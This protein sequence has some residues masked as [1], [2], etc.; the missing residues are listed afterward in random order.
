MPPNPPSSPASASQLPAAPASATPANLAKAALRRLAEQRLE[1]TPDNFRKAYEVEAGVSP[2]APAVPDRVAASEPVPSQAEEGERWSKLIGRILR[3]AERGGRQWTAARKK[4]SLQRVLEG[5]KN[6]A[7][8]LH[9]RLSQLVQSWDSDTLDNTLL[10]D[11]AESPDDTASVAPPDDASLDT[12]TD[13]P[14]ADDADRRGIAQVGIELVGRETDEARHHLRQH[15][16]ENDVHEGG[17]GGADGLDLLDGPVSLSVNGA[18]K[19]TGKGR[20][21][22]DGAFGAAAW[23]ANVLAA[24]G[25][26]LKAGDFIGI[27]GQT[28][29]YMVTSDANSDA[30]GNATLNIEPAL[31]AVP[32]DVAALTVR[33]VP[34]TLA[35]ASDTIEMGVQPPV[36]YN[37][38]LS[39]V[40]AF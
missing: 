35:L 40:E 15:T 1:P 14:A 32:T 34:F 5:S 7:Q 18:V 16:E 25:R 12:G 4:D 13:A 10:D 30:S 20:N 8:R 6:S 31:M 28:K 24:K 9:Q 2:A 22:D 37:F 3:G 21:V 38:S 26:G 27:T 29:V 19:A 23:L 33:N 11:V 36:L 39:L 17:T